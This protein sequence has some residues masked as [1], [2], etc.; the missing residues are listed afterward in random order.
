MAD[1]GAQME[2][3]DIVIKD[4]KAE[5]YDM[6]KELNGIRGFLGGVAEA[7]ELSGEEA[8]LDNIAKKIQE[9]TGSE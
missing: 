5:V 9:L 7:L 8:T 2:D 3:K 1:L 6:G 4:L